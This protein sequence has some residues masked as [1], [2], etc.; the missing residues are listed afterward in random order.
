MYKRR[1]L[2]LRQSRQKQI[3]SQR[4]CTCTHICT[5]SPGMLATHVRSCTRREGSWCVS[6]TKHHWRARYVMPWYEDIIKAMPGRLEP[7]RT[8]PSL[9]PRLFPTSNTSWEGRPSAA[10]ISLYEVQRGLQLPADIQ[11]KS[12]ISPSFAPPPWLRRC[13]CCHLII[14]PNTPPIRGE[15]IY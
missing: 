5:W 14:I 7:S 12:F 9:H 11:L 6:L 2:I 10:Y 8:P 4:L 1:T 3:Y 15:S 13:S